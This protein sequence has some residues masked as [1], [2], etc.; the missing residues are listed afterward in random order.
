MFAT[1]VFIAFVAKLLS[2][3]Y[4]VSPINLVAKSIILA[5]DYTTT[6]NL[7]LNSD[8]SISVELFNYIV[9]FKEF[10]HYEHLQTIYDYMTTSYL[11]MGVK[12]V[13]E[14]MKI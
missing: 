1:I 9:E 10:S 6:L 3:T 4:I 8:N 13:L 11:D 14:M 7:F 12:Y 2:L 5:P